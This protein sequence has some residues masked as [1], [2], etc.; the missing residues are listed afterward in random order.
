MFW[1]SAMSSSVG[2]A[3][4]QF[5]ITRSSLV[6]PGMGMAPWRHTQPMATCAVVT[7]L[8]LAICS[9]ASTSLKFWSKT[10]GLKRGSMRRKSFCGRSSSLRNSPVSQPRL[11]GLYATMGMPTVGVDHAVSRWLLT[12][13]FSRIT[14]AH[15]THPRYRC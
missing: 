7:P 15:G 8:R 1:I 5:S 9:T 4:L 10:S 13:C 14:Y 6:E 11:M 2:D 3:A 12:F